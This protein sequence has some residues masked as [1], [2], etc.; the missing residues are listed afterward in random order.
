MEN[1]ESTPSIVSDSRDTI[2]IIEVPK[3]VFGAPE[4][5]SI[6]HKD[7][8]INGRV[9]DIEVIKQESPGNCVEYTAL[10]VSLL[11]K[12]G[13]YVNPLVKQYLETG[14]SRKLDSVE[15]DVVL[16]I[17]LNKHD[18]STGLKPELVDVENLGEKLSNPYA[19]LTMFN[20]TLLFKACVTPINIG[21]NFSSEDIVDRYT[22]NVDNRITSTELIAVLVGH[23]SHATCYLKLGNRCYFIDPYFNEG[24]ISELPLNQMRHEISEKLGE[25]RSGTFISMNE[26]YVG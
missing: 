22:R 21:L 12:A 24:V 13:I 19:P 16:P 10:N 14:S 17:L 18:K 3:G 8:N 9:Q 1:T 26:L 2:N 20:T 15:K 25:H 4:D 11:S 7:L 5:Y 23:R 6:K